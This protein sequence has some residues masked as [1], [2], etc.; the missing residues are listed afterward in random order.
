LLPV[1]VFTTGIIP[2]IRLVIDIVGANQQHYRKSNIV[3][4]KHQQCRKE[5]KPKRNFERAQLEC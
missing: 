3:G 5:K 1:H 2:K 4:A